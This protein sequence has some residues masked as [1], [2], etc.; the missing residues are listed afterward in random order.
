MY[1]ITKEEAVQEALEL[2][3]TYDGSLTMEEA[4]EAVMESAKTDD[5]G[6]DDYSAESY[7]NYNNYGY[8]TSDKEAAVEEALDLYH[9]YDITMEEAMDTVLAMR[10]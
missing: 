3:H 9:R 8:G 1:N 4:M 10:S 5:Y 6:Y 2:Y 7:Y